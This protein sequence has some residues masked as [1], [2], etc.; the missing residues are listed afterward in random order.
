RRPEENH[1]RSVFKAEID[2]YD[3]AASSEEVS[4]LI[5]GNFQLFTVDHVTDKQVTDV[6]DEFFPDLAFKTDFVKG[7]FH[8]IGVV[9]SVE[10]LRVRRLFMEAGIHHTIDM[11]ITLG[12]E[13]RILKAVDFA[14]KEHEL[15]HGG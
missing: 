9:D 12:P 10:A 14:T 13:G 2:A 5:P 6:T 15:M 8:K 1:V 3:A 11:S 7:H 4:R